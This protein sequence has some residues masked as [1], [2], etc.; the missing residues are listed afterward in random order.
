[1]CNGG[2]KGRGLLLGARCGSVDKVGG[3]G[4]GRGLGGGEG[5]V[6]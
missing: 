5:G 1:V 4:S 3:G 6:L 2:G